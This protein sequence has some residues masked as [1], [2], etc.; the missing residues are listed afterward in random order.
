MAQTDSSLRQWCTTGQ[1][2][3]VIAISET[4]LNKQL[5]TYYD[6]NSN[7][8]TMKVDN[9]M[10][11]TLDVELGPPR[12]SIVIKDLARTSVNYHV[13]MKQGT[14]GYYDEPAYR[15]AI[16]DEPVMETVKDWEFVFAVDVVEGPEKEK[17]KETLRVKGDYSIERLLLMFSTAKV[18]SWNQ[19]LSK[20]RMLDQSQPTAELMDTIGGLVGGWLVKYDQLENRLRG[21][22]VRPDAKTKKLVEKAVNFPLLYHA[23]PQDPA[24]A[25]PNIPSFPPSIV[26]HQTYEFV[27]NADVK[28]KRLTNTTDRNC[29]MYLE[30]CKNVKNLPEKRLFE[31]TNGNFVTADAKNQIDGSMC[32]TRDLL[33][34]GYLVPFF[35]PVIKQSQ[36]YITQA[37][38]DR[39]AEK[40]FS[41]NYRFGD[42]GTHQDY[43]NDF[44]LMKSMK[45]QSDGAWKDWF[46][47]RVDD[48][49]NKA[50]WQWK[51]ELQKKDANTDSTFHD[52]DISV[53]VAVTG[54][55]TIALTFQAEKGAKFAVDVTYP[56]EVEFK[57]WKSEAANIDSVDM[58]T[59]EK[60]L[61]T[62]LQENLNSVKPYINTLKDTLKSQA[63]VLAGGGYFDMVN[64]IFTHNGDLLVELKYV[65]L[66]GDD[67]TEQLGGI[68]KVTVDV[69]GDVNASVAS[70][71]LSFGLKK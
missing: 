47:N 12:V 58:K 19:T 17:I 5:K 26:T 54:S 66:K 25:N 23:M 41:W 32:F 43:S 39:S 11:G 62:K 4:M 3:Q 42:D 68:E 67:K 2:H 36:V 46:N 63:F 30:M 1:Y 22:E 71:T 52:T 64:P 10:L 38:T 27:R 8:R 55:F 65:E 29:L 56:E 15:R 59:I 16:T 51:T 53:G 61:K 70:S 21:V 18:S 6:K 48:M 49:E 13:Y 34:D 31:E 69:P 37:W 57:A 24:L 7:F 28:E 44:F 20:I 60:D 45:V 40:M 14:I 33:F 50:G 9:A 35:N